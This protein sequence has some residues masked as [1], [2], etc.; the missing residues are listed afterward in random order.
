M[1]K[2][3]GLVFR[4][5]EK[6]VCSSPV[7]VEAPGSALDTPSWCVLPFGAGA[8]ELPDPAPCLEVD[9]GGEDGLSTLSVPYNTASQDKLSMF[10]I[11]FIG[12]TLLNSIL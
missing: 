3:Q 4:P 7:G 9:M 6:G 8:T 5:Q 10:R 1:G 12:V 11:K 2:A